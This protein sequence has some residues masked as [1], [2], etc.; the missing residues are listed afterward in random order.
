MIPLPLS[1][2][3]LFEGVGILDETLGEGG[4]GGGDVVWVVPPEFDDGVL[5]G[6]GEG[7]GDG[8][9]EGALL[10][11][12]MEVG[13]GLVDGLPARQEDDTG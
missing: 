8:P 6:A 7:E 11:D 10:D 5:E 3:L 2:G 1:R 9:R 4:L 12:L 13:G